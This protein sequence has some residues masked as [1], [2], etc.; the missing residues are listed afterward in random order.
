MG[1]RT[2]PRIV[3]ALLAVLWALRFAPALAQKWPRDDASVGSVVWARVVGQECQGVL[4]PYEIGQL[5]AYLA[6]AAAE[7]KSRPDLADQSFDTFVKGLAAGYAKDYPSACRDD[8]VEARDI[9]QR[10]RRAL[11]SGKPLL[12]EDP[13][14]DAHSK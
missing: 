2:A 11:A 13:P 5:D 9:L 7:W 1:A 14:D 3:A 4:S 12:P 6:R 8:E 10:V